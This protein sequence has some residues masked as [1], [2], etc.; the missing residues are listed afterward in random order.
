AAAVRPDQHDLLITV[1]DTGIGISPAFREPV[2]GRF[3]RFE[4]HA[5]VLDIAGTGLGLPIARELVEMHCG[6]I[7]FES[8]VDRAT[9][10][11][12]APPLPENVEQPKPATD[13][14]MALED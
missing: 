11:Y 6:E 1:A 3:E 2:W 5:L 14:R 10:F 9:T 13:S 7:W 12:V 8:E 4:E